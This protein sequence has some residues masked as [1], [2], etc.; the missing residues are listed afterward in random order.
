MNHYIILPKKEYCG[1]LS[2]LDTICNNLDNYIVKETIVNIYNLV[3]N[4]PI[5][6]NGNIINLTSEYE[7]I[8]MVSHK[9]CPNNHKCDGCDNEILYICSEYQNNDELLKIQLVEIALNSNVDINA[10]CCSECN[11]LNYCINNKLFMLAKYLIEKKINVNYSHMIELLNSIIYKKYIFIEQ[12]F[13]FLQ[14][15]IDTIGIINIKTNKDYNNCF[16]LCMSVAFSICANLQNGN[17]NI[18]EIVDLYKKPMEKDSDS[19]RHLFLYLLKILLNISGNSYGDTLIHISKIFLT[20]KKFMIDD[21]TIDTFKLVK[22]ACS[23]KTIEEL[24][25]IYFGWLTQEDIPYDDA[26]NYT[27]KRPSRYNRELLIL[28]DAMELRISDITNNKKIKLLTDTMINL[29]SS[30]IS[31]VKKSVFIELID[32]CDNNTIL[33]N[34][35]N[36]LPPVNIFTGYIKKKFAMIKTIKNKS[37]VVV[38]KGILKKEQL[39]KTLFLIKNVV[40]SNMKTMIM[41]KII[42]LIL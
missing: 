42:P 41:R 15:L 30:K 6:D 1:M 38:N 33:E 26:A 8:K 29:F 24:N 22:N 32:Y 20:N 21:I 10:R 3:K 14:L 28:A 37:G 2:Q 11:A 25:K 40:N 9:K 18:I 17:I 12:I 39:L 13:D 7:Y 16:N 35:K 23:K 19:V 27:C 36:N 31:A 5:I 34:V 4:I